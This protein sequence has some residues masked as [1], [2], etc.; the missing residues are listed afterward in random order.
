[1]IR[2]MVKLSDVE[3]LKD[4]GI[5]ITDHMREEIKKRNRRFF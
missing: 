3:K 4:N 5:T 1:M 2:D